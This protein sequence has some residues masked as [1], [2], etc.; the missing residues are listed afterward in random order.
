MAEPSLAIYCLFDRGFMHIFFR[1]LNLL[2]SGTPPNAMHLAQSASAT[3]T[4][5]SEAATLHIEFAVFAWNFPPAKPGRGKKRFSRHSDRWSWKFE[6]QLD[7]DGRF[8]Q[9]CSPQH[10][11]L[12]KKTILT[13]LEKLFTR[14][15]ARTVLRQRAGGTST[16]LP[17]TSSRK[18]RRCWESRSL[19]GSRPAPEFAIGMMERTRS[20]PAGT[21]RQVSLSRLG[22]AE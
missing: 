4:E 16:S 19:C 12:A 22:T 6:A 2:R 10:A 21:V 14:L 1:A 3:S 5:E 11:R 15:L 8:I 13:I 17:P 20:F 9:T 18:G 7:A